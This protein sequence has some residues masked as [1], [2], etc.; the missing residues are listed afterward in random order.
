MLLSIVDELGLD[1][2]ASWMIGDTARDLGAAHRAG[3]RCAL[4][5]QVDRCELCQWVGAPPTGLTP[6]LSAP[7]LDELAT[8]IL[9]ADGG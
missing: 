7:R 8:A 6:A 1:R 2:A 4:L 9:E 3:I 5:L